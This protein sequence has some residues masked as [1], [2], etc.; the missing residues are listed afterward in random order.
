MRRENR[1]SISRF[2]FELFIVFIGVYGA[3]ELNRYQQNQRES[4]IKENY[5]VSF[6]SELKNIVS[7][8]RNA[9]ETIDTELSELAAY[10]DSI[11]EKPFIPAFISFKQALLITQAGFNDDVFVQLDP[12]LASSLTGGYDYIKNIENMVDL[13]NETAASKLSGLT[14]KDLFDENGE[15]KKEFA[16]YESKL[17]SLK[18]N[19]SDIGSMLQNDAMPAVNAIIQKF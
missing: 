3:F 16:W 2:I 10:T 8:I 6:S 13:F 15:I 9:Q 1:L 7:N 12:S 14:W 19:F 18:A 17:L 4:K 5:F 11:A